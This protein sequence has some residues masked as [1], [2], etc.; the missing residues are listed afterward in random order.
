MGNKLFKLANA[1]VHRAETS[2]NA[3][4]TPEE[5]SEA[6]TKISVAKNDV[7]SAYANSTMAEKEQ[8]QEMQ[9]RLEKAE[10][11]LHSGRKIKYW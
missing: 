8:L 4:M 6:T 1:A 7:S 10:Q 3:A 5:Y 11:S 9:Q 2:S